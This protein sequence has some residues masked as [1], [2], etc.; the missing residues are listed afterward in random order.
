MKCYQYV[1]S[2]AKRKKF[3]CL[4]ALY[5]ILCIVAFFTLSHTCNYLGISSYYYEEY[6]I[7]FLLLYLNVVISTFLWQVK[8]ITS[9]LGY[10]IV[11]L[12]Y[13][14]IFVLLFILTIN[15]TKFPLFLLVFFSGLALLF[16]LLTACCYFTCIVSIRDEYSIEDDVSFI[17]LGCCIYCSYV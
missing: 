16:N 3:F 1:F 9:N 14:Y 7:G 11:F 17:H 2:N 6:K 13:A 15:S 5:I 12:I 4:T 10:T 8:R